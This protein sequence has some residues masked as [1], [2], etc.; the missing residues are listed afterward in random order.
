MSEVYFY[1]NNRRTGHVGEVLSGEA[2]GSEALRIRATRPK[3][4]AGRIFEV[5]KSEV[6]VLRKGAG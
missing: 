3:A 6:R 5:P 4:F 2:G 1:A